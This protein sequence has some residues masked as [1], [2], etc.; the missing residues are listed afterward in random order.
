MLEEMFS[1]FNCVCVCVPMPT[2]FGFH[3]GGIDCV[4]VVYFQI[5]HHCGRPHY[6]TVALRSLVRVVYVWPGD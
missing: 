4:D 5:T 1:F 6:I 3:T 2:R